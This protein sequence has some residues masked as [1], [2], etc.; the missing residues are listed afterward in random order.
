M[1]LHKTHQETQQRVPTYHDPWA[2]REAW[3]KNPIFSN[4]AMVRN[5]FPGLGI[6]TVAFTIYCGYDWA[7][8]KKEH[9]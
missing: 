3:R 4:R 6:A 8:G 5:M 2:R 7:F 9:H 1:S